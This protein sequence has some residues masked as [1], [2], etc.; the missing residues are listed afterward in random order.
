MKIT[1]GGVKRS[2]WLNRTIRNR[3][4]RRPRRLRRL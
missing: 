4:A 1:R 2:A 3:V